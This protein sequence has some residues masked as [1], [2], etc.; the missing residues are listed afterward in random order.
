MWNK[1]PMAERAKYIQL[2]IQNGITDL[3]TIRRSYNSFARGG[4]T[5]WKEGIKEHKGIDVDNDSTYDY[6]GFY[7][8]DP[9]RAWEMLDK[10]KNVHF[11]DEYKTVYHPTFSNQSIYSGVKHPEFNPNGINGGTWDKDGKTFT[12]SD[13]LYRG[14]VS[15]D[16]RIS[17]LSENEDNGVQLIE[18]N[19]SYPVMIDNALLGPVL[20]TVYVEAATTRRNNI[21]KDRENTHNFMLPLYIKDSTAH[22]EPTEDTIYAP[23]DSGEFY[24]HE[25]FHARPNR[26]MLDELFPYYDKLNDNRLLELGADMDFIMRSGDPGQYYSPEEVGARVA[27]STQAL[28]RAGIK[29]ITDEWINSVR[30]NETKYGDNFRDLL[31]MYNNANLINIL[32]IGRRYYPKR[33]NK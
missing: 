32:N 22:Y 26:T 9:D 7:N 16:D 30:K 23:E 20:P 12:M 8:S 1:L 17:Y 10:D 13:D 28:N 21:K 33:N 31:R 5:K 15:M 24:D 29:D 2:A 6:E 11:T 18:S 14:P 4:Y 27:A 19:G 3:N 25:M